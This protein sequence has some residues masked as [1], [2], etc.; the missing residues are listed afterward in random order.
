[1]RPE[2]KEGTV[3]RIVTVLLVVVVWGSVAPAAA[4]TRAEAPQAA[5]SMTWYVVGSG[6]VIGSTGGGYTMGGTI[7]QPAIGWSENGTTLGSGFWYG[8]GPRPWHVY[9]PIILK[10]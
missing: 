6:G 9:L 5:Y 3:L 2:C 8:T 7:G 1:M 4:P 10:E